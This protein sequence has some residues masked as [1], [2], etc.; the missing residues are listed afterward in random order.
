MTVLDELA[1]KGRAPMTGY[2]RDRFGSAWTDDNTDLWGH[3]GCDTRNDILRRDLTRQVI[4]SGTGGCVVLTGVLHAPY[5][6]RRIAF[7]RGVDTSTA[8]EI[9]H[10][11]SVLRTV[12]RCV[13]RGHAVS[14]IPPT[15]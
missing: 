4:E 15:A 13:V 5:T 14:D 6:G 11:V 10:V 12:L 2:S 1:V 8:V 9:D 7:T 3:N